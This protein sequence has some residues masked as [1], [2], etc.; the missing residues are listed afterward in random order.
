MA[1]SRKP[2]STRAIRIRPGKRPPIRKTRRR[3]TK[4][5]Q[6]ELPHIP[7]GLRV[8]IEEQRG[9]LIA[10]MTLLHCLHVVLEHQ[11]DHGG[12]AL[13]AGAKAAIRWANLPDMTEMLLERVHAVHLALDSVCL[14]RALQSFRE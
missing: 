11:K 7:E 2:Q 6:T 3:H 1:A 9:V 10:V 14:A 12:E 4:P 5:S 13:S 8:E